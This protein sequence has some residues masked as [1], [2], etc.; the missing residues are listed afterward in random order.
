MINNEKS[1][2]YINFYIIIVKN[3]ETDSNDPRLLS[4]GTP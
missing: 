3:Q 2:K 1:M 4:A